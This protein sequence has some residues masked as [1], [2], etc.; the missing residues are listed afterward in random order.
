MSLYSK[1]KCAAEELSVWKT[2]VLKYLIDNRIDPE[3]LKMRFQKNYNGNCKIYTYKQEF[4]NSRKSIRYL[5]DE[6]YFRGKFST[7][8]WMGIYWYRCE[9]QDYLNDK[10][11]REWDLQEL[12]KRQ[13]IQKLK[14]SGIV[15]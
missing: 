10:D 14:N 15:K 8:Q 4:E 6:G 7:E 2:E 9:W 1:D 12:R 5:E 3:L 13:D 11:Q